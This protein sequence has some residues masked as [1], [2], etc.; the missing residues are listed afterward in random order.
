M[1]DNKDAQVYDEVL[2]LWQYLGD[3]LAIDQSR[4]N[5]ERVFE[6]MRERE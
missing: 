5:R 3:K 4:L 1:R 6:E 2:S